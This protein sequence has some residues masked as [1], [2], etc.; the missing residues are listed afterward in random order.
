MSTESKDKVT[1]ETFERRNGIGSIIYM[2]INIVNY[3]HY[4]FI[5]F[6]RIVSVKIKYNGKDI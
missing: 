5:L 4:V 1:C 6:P 2:Y 3:F